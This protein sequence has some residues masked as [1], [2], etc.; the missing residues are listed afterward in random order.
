M[1]DSQ[2]SY[3]GVTLGDRDYTDLNSWIVIALSE[4]KAL[5]DHDYVSLAYQ[6][7][8]EGSNLPM[9]GSFAL[10]KRNEF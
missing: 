8:A 10:F 5:S 7:W 3:L 2:T 1:K 4:E 6:N 9:P